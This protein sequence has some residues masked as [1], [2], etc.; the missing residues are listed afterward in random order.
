LLEKVEDVRARASIVW[1]IGEYAESIPT[2][3][4]DILRHLAR[5]FT[6]EAVEVKIQALNLGLKLYFRTPEHC[7]TLF[8][9]VLELASFDL[10]YD[11]R[12]KARLLLGVIS[13]TG[14]L[15]AEAKALFLTAKP[16]PKFLDP[17]EGRHR[18]TVSSLSHVLNSKL[19][20]FEGLP[21][22]PEEMDLDA[23]E[24]RGADKYGMASTVGQQGIPDQWN[25]E[26]S[27]ELDSDE[28]E[29]E[30]EEEEEEGGSDDVRRLSTE[31]SSEVRSDALS[32]ADPST[33]DFD[34]LFSG[35]PVTPVAIASNPSDQAGL[36]DNIFSGFGT[37]AAEPVTPAPVGSLLGAINAAGTA[38][39]EEEDPAEFYPPSPQKFRI[40]DAAAGHGLSLVSCF[41]RQK[42]AMGDKYSTIELAI[43]NETEAPIQGVNVCDTKGFDIHPFAQIAEIGPGICV[44]VDMAVHFSSLTEPVQFQME[45]DEKQFTVSVAPV[46]GEIIR[47]CVITLDAFVEES[48]RV[49]GEGVAFA[50]LA[51][52]VEDEEAVVSKMSDVANV[53]RV[54]GTAE[55]EWF[56][57][58]ELMVDSRVY[59]SINTAE[60][61]TVKCTD[62]SL[63]ELLGNYFK[64]H[65]GK[66][67]EEEVEK[68]KEEEQEQEG[69]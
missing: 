58:G 9:Y 27:S 69:N 32:I 52:N 57:F 15:G 43:T 17:S 65:F 62:D 25:D 59:V 16:Q 23:R 42:S 19:S 24:I 33:P 10:N 13:S 8:R 20:L 47:P 54:K 36:L 4:P 41:Q 29:G 35:A 12:D 26:W 31:W 63:T 56:F 37:E 11:V 46:V 44:T 45:A 5:S 48:G 21:S 61:G 34:S 38:E 28:F 39:E 6:S 67:E 7:E 3:A 18:F 2:F 60:G 22:F 68:G 51:E 50:C 53:F 30:E 1:V 55:K 66:S 14:F 49:E 64:A 40:V